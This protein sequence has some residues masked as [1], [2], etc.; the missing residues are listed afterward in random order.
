MNGLNIYKNPNEIDSY[1]NNNINNNNVITYNNNNIG[2]TNI[3]P[4]NNYYQPN[5]VQNQYSNNN[6]PNN[7]FSN[8]NIPF[9][10]EPF[11]NPQRYQPDYNRVIYVKKDEEKDCGSVC[12]GNCCLCIGI[13]C[14]V[15]CLLIVVA[16]ILLVNNWKI[17][18][19]YDY[20][21]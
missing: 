15:I 10:N 16:F 3:F 18:N 17:T 19:N 11:M 9:Y 2:G 1:N 21:D 7:N 14:G 12:L 4:E 5:L 8:N 6:F 20:N 13:F